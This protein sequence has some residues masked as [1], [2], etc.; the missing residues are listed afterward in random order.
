MEI[1]VGDIVRFNDKVLSL[2]AIWCHNHNIAGLVVEAFSAGCNIW[3]VDTVLKYPIWVLGEHLHVVAN[4]KDSPP[5][6]DIGC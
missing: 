1:K 6:D 4:I 2:A 3:K 5:L